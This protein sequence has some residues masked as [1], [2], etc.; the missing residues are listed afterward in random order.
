MH[1]VAC[2]H[3]VFSGLRGPAHGRPRMACVV[4]RTVSLFSP[5]WTS[6]WS[7]SF[8]L[9]GPARP[10]MPEPETGASKPRHTCYRILGLLGPASPHMPEP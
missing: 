8:G 3:V 2:K 10:H 7:A 5:A 9:L 1:G 4:M 6:S